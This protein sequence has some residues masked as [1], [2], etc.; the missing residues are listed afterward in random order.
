MKADVAADS[1]DLKRVIALAE[2]YP[3]ITTQLH[4]IQGATRSVTEVYLL[5]PTGVVPSAPFEEFESV[6]KVVR[7][8]QSFRA[9]GRHDRRLEAVG[10]RYVGV[11]LSQVSFHV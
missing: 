4:R 2:S 7:V 3:G 6:E 9:I 11:Q 1:P 5:G 10:L 8:T